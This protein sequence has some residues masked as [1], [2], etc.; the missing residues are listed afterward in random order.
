MGILLPGHGAGTEHLLSAERL[1]R[2]GLRPAG[3]A[4]DPQLTILC[5]WLWGRAPLGGPGEGFCFHPPG[6][7][8]P[9]GVQ[10]WAYSPRR[11]ASGGEGLGSPSS[12]RVLPG[13]EGVLG[14]SSWEPQPCRNLGTHFPASCSFYRDVK[15]DNIL[16]DERGEPRR[17]SPEPRRVCTPAR[18]THPLATVML[19]S[20]LTGHAHLTDFNIATI[21]KDG[22]R[23]TALAGTK[24]YMGEPRPP[25]PRPPP[26]CRPVSC[27]G[28]WLVRSGH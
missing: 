25:S 23:A 4:T 22:E 6:A 18:R 28:L 24:P 16:L 15:P 3:G 13:G 27:P 8:V 19:S 9:L 2:Q 14:P 5:S 7:S 11:L 20:P 1:G 12:A 26:A 10:R 17:V 21:I